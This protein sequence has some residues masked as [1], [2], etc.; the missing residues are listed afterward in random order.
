MNIWHTEYKWLFSLEYKV[1]QHSTTL[2]QRKN[3]CNV[4]LKWGGELT[5]YFNEELLLFQTVFTCQT[6]EWTQGL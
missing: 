5:Q 1:D 6:S 3:Y 4:T 2:K